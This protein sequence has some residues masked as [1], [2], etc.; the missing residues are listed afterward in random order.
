[1]TA[2]SATLFRQFPSEPCVGYTDPASRGRNT[3]GETHVSTP[4][5]M[6]RPADGGLNVGPYKR[7]AAGRVRCG[8]FRHFRRR[9]HSYLPAFRHGAHASH[10][11]CGASDTVTTDARTPLSG[12]APRNTVGRLTGSRPDRTQMLSGFYFCAI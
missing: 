10:Y 8:S 12:E 2:A 11:P 9:R 1:M 5:Q 3:W 6:P 7:V 4:T